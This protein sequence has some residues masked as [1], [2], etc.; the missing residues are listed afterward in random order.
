MEQHETS[1]IPVSHIMPTNDTPLATLVL[2]RRSSI[3][4]K[5]DGFEMVFALCR[6]GFNGDQPIDW[7]SII[8]PEKTD[9]YQELARRITNY[10]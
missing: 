10:K 2:N 6:L 3:E 1:Q 5:D 4:C 8:L 7:E 9:L